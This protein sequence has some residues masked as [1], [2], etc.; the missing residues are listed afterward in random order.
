MPIGSVSNLAPTI[1]HLTNAFSPIL[2]R[3]KIADLGIGFGIYGAAVRQ[4]MDSGVNR[5]ASPSTRHL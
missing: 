3:V 5:W 2:S 1:R 4:W